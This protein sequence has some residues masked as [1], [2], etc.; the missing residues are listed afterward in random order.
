M[1]ILIT[2][3]SFGSP[4]HKAERLLKDKGFE[5]MV[6]SS[7][8][9]LSENQM[10]DFLSECDG[11]IVGIDPLNQRVLQKSTRLKAI[12]K[13]GT[14]VDNID[15]DYCL[16]HGIHVSTTAGANSEAVADFT[17]ALILAVA[18]QVIVIDRQCHLH[19]WDK[20]RSLDIYGKKIG[21]IGLG[22]IGKAVARRAKGF[23]MDI[24]ACDPVWD[25]RFANQLNIKKE[26]LDEICKQADILTLHVP[27]L[28]STRH[29]IGKSQIDRMKP[30]AILINTARGGLID[31]EALLHALAH[32]RIYG[33]G[34]DAF[35]KEPPED[36]EW[37]A[38]DNLVMGSHTAA[39]TD[40]AVSSMSLAAA[41]NLIRDLEPF[42][43]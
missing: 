42:M 27:L 31:E 6:N 41:K 13:Y 5:I 23:N 19:K 12:A 10:I 36:P 2:P 40:G 18:R 11:V 39:S 38:L 8:L 37:Y 9:V 4:D 33:A 15:M 16:E 3:R 29:I 35:T 7:G 34:I 17:F 22:Q 21:I 26:T 28:L 20:I 32:H 43:K 30:S 1:K 24:I 25:E 14:G